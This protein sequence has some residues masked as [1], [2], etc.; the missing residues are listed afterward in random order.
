MDI[1]LDFNKTEVYE[2]GAILVSVLAYPQEGHSGRRVEAHRALCA[3]ALRERAAEDEAWAESPQ[4]IKPLYILSDREID[5]GL[6]TLKRRLRDR[7]VAG[8]MAMVYLK[9]V[10]A[11][12]RWRLPKRL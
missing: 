7:M 1:T 6:K 10:V 5:A 3:I 8:R 4:P 2:A 11:N 12:G 9:D